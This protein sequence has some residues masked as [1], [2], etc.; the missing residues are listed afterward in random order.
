MATPSVRVCC[1]QGERRRV[2]ATYRDRNPT[3]TAEVLIGLTRR[4][5][6]SAV[7]LCP[8]NLVQISVPFSGLQEP[9]ME[10]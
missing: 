7:C 9:K 2:G 3:S 10:P 8:K 5:S 1:A 6:L 4:R